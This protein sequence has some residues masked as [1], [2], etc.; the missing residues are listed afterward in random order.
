MALR[1]R[2]P[3]LQSFAGGREAPHA[4]GFETRA[5]HA[6]QRPD[7][8]TGAR[9]VP[10]YQTTG[11]RLRGHRVRRGVLQPAGVRQHLLAHHEP[12]RR[13]LRGAHRQPR[14]RRGRGGLR[15]RP[16]RRRRGHL[17]AAAAR[18]PHRRRRGRSTAARI[19]QFKT[20]CSQSRRWTFTLRRPATIPPRG[21]AAITPKTKLLFGE[22]IGN[23]GGNILDIRAVADVAHAHGV[24]ADGRQ[25]LCH[26]V[27]VPADRVRRGHRGA[28]GDE[29][30][31]RARDEHRRRGGRIRARSTGRTGA[32]RRGR[33]VAGLPRART[34]T[35]PSACTAS[36]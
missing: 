34:S 18:R 23:P 8:Y 3:D 25:H 27:P 36:S 6:G 15:Q 35:R 2:N 14:R 5:V 26:A 13:R 31:R 4:F 7:P 33:A 1:T 12:D 11:L 32:S 9:A 21:E 29:V 24:A 19:T 16:R 17:H 28:L 30:H 20:R 22:T 10:I